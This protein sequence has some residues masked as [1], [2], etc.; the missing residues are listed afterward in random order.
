MK[1]TID[2]SESKCEKCGEIGRMDRH[3]K[4]H[5]KL[6]LQAF[7]SV[8]K[9]R[10]TK[11]YERLRRRYEAFA[12]EDIAFLCRNCHEEIH[13]AY[14]IAITEWLQGSYIHDLN[15]REA[16]K[17]MNHLG[18]VFKKW[19]NDPNYWERDG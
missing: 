18:K 4:K 14:R 3:H 19:V 15:W 2:F 6:I 13:T 17:L 9:R 16:R 10:A 1:L 8:P 11:A 7:R 5:Q 12:A